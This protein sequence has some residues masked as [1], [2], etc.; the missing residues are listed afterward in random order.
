MVS[1]LS[2]EQ[3]VE[4]ATLKKLVLV[5]IKSIYELDNMKMVHLEKYL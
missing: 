1:D 2:D 3:I 5:D 4:L